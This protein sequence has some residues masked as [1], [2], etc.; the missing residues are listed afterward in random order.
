M[1]PDVNTDEGNQR[2]KRILVGSGD[3]LELLGLGVVTEPSPAGTLNSSCGVV[4]FGLESYMKWDSEYFCDGN[5]V[6]AWE[7]GPY[8]QWNQ[9]HAR[10]QP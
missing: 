3:D 10:E 9:S 7:F 6:E 5:R 2:E 8:L 1:L 4:H